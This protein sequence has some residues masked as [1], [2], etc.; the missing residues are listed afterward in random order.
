MTGSTGLAGG[1]TAGH[2][3]D[4]FRRPLPLMKSRFCFRVEV[5]PEVNPE[6][7][8]Y[9][10]YR[11]SVRNYR[12]E[13]PWLLPKASSAYEKS[14]LFPS[15]SGTGSN[16][17]STGVPVLPVLTAEVPPRRVEPFRRPLVSCFGWAGST[18]LCAGTTGPAGFL[19][20]P[21]VSFFV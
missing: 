19:F 10:Y 6:V 11:P 17:G 1:T 14:P 15:G 18:A 2:F 16:P 3:R 9:R 8:V 4:Y 5:A 7:P 12:W 20:Y 21:L 13:L